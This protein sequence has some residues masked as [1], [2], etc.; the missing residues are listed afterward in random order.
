VKE[1]DLDRHPDLDGR[2]PIAWYRLV[3][4]ETRWGFA[5]DMCPRCGR[6]CDPGHTHPGPLIGDDPLGH[7]RVVV[8]PCCDE[9]YVLRPGNRISTEL[10]VEEVRLRKRQSEID[11]GA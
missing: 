11:S 1:R 8:P 10:F 3:I 7:Q 4:D 9:P 2:F 6:F 5:V